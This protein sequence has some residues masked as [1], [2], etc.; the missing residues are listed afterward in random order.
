M[1]DN[2]GKTVYRGFPV[3]DLDTIKAAWNKIRSDRSLSFNPVFLSYID[4]LNFQSLENKTG[5][6]IISATFTPVKYNKVAFHKGEFVIRTPHQY[7]K[8]DFNSETVGEHIAE[9]VGLKKGLTAVRDI[10]MKLSS[11]MCG[12]TK[13]G[14]NNIAYTEEFGSYITLMAFH[15]DEIV[16]DSKLKDPERMECCESCRSCETNCPGSALR[17]GSYLEVENCMTLHNE[18]EGEF[19]EPVLSMAH[20]A[21]MGCLICQESC[22]ANSDINPRLDGKPLC[23]EET[24]SLFNRELSEPGLR[25]LEKL[26]GVSNKES[27]KEH[28]P[29]YARNF[30]YAMKTITGC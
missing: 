4:S 7:Y 5:S 21:M 2:S 27:L 30:H 25:G 19:Q 10:P 22:P 14:R 26:L 18:I 24:R 28:F 6:L 8:A 29:V 12:L 23:E 15:T 9:K 16:M 17:T 13:Y 1:N 11:A 3:K 20:H